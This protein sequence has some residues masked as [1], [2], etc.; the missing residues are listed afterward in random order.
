MKKLLY[1]IWFAIIP[2]FLIVEIVSLIK[3]YDAISGIASF[4][5]AI[6]VACAVLV[7]IKYKER[8]R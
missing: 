4:C 2:I 3:G 7:Y 8:K 5:F 1:I 6:C